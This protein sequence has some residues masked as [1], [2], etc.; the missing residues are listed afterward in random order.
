MLAAADAQKAVASAC[1]RF[2]LRC[3]SVA[4]GYLLPRLALE[5]QQ[6]STHQA[7]QSVVSH[8][9]DVVVAI[10]TQDVFDRLW[11]R[12]DERRLPE[13]AHSKDVSVAMPMR[14]EHMK[15]VTRSAQQS[16]VPDQRPGSRARSGSRVG[17][18]VRVRLVEL[19]DIQPTRL[20]R[21]CGRVIG[22]R[23]PNADP[24]RAGA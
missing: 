18:R 2:A 19:V 1:A 23:R 12:D 5:G 13:D 8:A 21:L 9:L 20:A 17:V 14:F 22:A 11:M 6:A 10:R 16:R 7:A 3:N 4:S 15:R 24:A